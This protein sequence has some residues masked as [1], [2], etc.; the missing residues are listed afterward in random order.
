M[1]VPDIIIFKRVR[2]GEIG[3]G[4]PSDID[5]LFVVEEIV[6]ISDNGNHLGGPVPLPVLI[7]DKIGCRFDLTALI[8]HIIESGP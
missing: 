7:A 3:K 8:V 4:L 6:G 1:T 5:S 2:G